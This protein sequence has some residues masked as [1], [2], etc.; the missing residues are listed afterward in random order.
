LD[1]T[2]DR[3]PLPAP[4]ASQS[5]QSAGPSTLRLPSISKLLPV[6]VFVEQATAPATPLVASGTAADAASRSVT[7]IAP[8]LER[9]DSF[10]STLSTLAPAADAPV[11][12]AV[13]SRLR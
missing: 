10:M 8:R 12:T 1:S 11:G 3:S 13:C 4:P 6:T 5:M 2:P 7:A 9:K